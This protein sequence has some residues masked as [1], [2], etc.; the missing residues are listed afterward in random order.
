MADSLASLFSDRDSPVD[1]DM[2]SNAPTLMSLPLEMLEHILSF[3]LPD[4]EVLRLARGWEMRPR[5]EVL[6]DESQDDGPEDDSPEDDGSEDDDLEDDGPEDESS[7]YDGP[8]GDGL[9]DDGLEDDGPEDVMK[10]PPLSGWWFDDEFRYD[11]EPVQ[12]AILCVNRLL[13]EE[14]S[15][16]LYGRALKVNIWMAISF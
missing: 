11:K 1:W 15:R 16:I 14:G 2:D 10:K 9:E 13:Y 12:T 8:E 4:K 7:E 6:S 5:P 3:L